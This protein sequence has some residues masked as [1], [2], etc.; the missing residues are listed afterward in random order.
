MSAD[1]KTALPSRR[2]LKISC[3][4]DMKRVYKLRHVSDAVLVGIGTVLADDPKLTVKEQYVPNPHQ[5]LRIILDSKCR[6]PKDAL[7]VN[8]RAQ[9]MI[10][11]SN[12]CSKTFGSNVEILQG[13]MDQNGFIDLH[14]L[15]LKLHRRGIQTLLVEGGSTVIWNF[16]REKLVD[17]LFVYL[18][19]LIV[20]G[21]HTPSMAGGDGI[22]S[23]EKAIHLKL[24]DVERIGPGL[25]LH[26]QLNSR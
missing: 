11:T 1:G 24:V 25:L 19:P 15:L 13:K 5:P 21:T 6:T 20:G 10:V 16:L 9:T 17:D 8:D 3:E 23:E 7:V 26:Y 14:D 18:G 4:E 12:S 2:Q 22:E